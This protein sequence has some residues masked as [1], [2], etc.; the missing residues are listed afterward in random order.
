VERECGM[1]AIF[2]ALNIVYDEEEKRGFIALNLRSLTF[3][4]GAI[5]F[6]LLAVAESSCSRSCSNTSGW[7]RG[8]MGALARPLA[9]PSDRRRVRSRPPVPLRTEPRPRD[10]EM[11]DAG[12]IAAAILWLVM[13]MLFSWYVSNF[14][15]YNETYG[16]LG[17]VI[18]FMTWIWL[19]SVVVLCGAEINAEVEH[20]TAQDTTEG[21][22]SR[23]ARGA[24]VADT[25]AQPRPDAEI[26]AGVEHQTAQDTTEGTSSR[27]ARGAPG[28]PI[29]W[30]QP[31][32]DAEINAGVEHQ[33]AQDTTE[34][35]KQPLGTR[36]ARMADTVAQPRPDAEIN[37]GWSTRPR[38][39]PR[40]AQAAARHAGRPDG[41]SQ[42]L[43]RSSVA[44]AIAVARS[45]ADDVE[46]QVI[47]VRRVRTGTEHGREPAA[48][49]RSQRQEGRVRGRV[50]FRLDPEHR[51]VRQFEARDVDR[52]AFRMGGQLAVGARFR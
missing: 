15:N 45:M 4:L 14:G 6:L 16:S 46:V 50:A 43:T 23:S 25:W 52:E 18:G 31:R 12:G 26:N 5:G 51:S 1:K 35:H 41:R 2:D 7:D 37:A 30:A 29:R 17:A 22:S 42:D 39:T 36:G 32:P 44:D 38:K 11:G 48:G 28:W 27:S 34:G 21:T 20:Q 24:P 3:T 49:R 10:L 40:G 8:R 13:S 9:D 47:V 19:S 33:T